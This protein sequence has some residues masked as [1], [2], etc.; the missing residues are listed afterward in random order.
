MPPGSRRRG[1]QP[2]RSGRR[3]PRPSVADRASPS[4]ARFSREWNGE[5]P[6]RP[7]WAARTPWWSPATSTSTRPS[8][9][10]RS[11]R[12]PT[13]ASSASRSSAST[14]T[15]R[16]PTTFTER[17]GARAAALTLGADQAYGPE[18][19][20]LASQDQLDKVHAHV[21]DAV[22][23]G[24]RLVAGGKHRPDIGPL[25]Y[26]PTVLADVTPDMDLY[27]DETFGPLCRRL[28]GRLRRRGRRPGQRHRVRPQRQR[29]LR[30]HRPRDGPS[31]NASWPARST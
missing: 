21:A 14:S 1:R 22:A 3:A 13:R 7:S 6:C 23:K 2:K 17:F 11:P 8:R 30:R 19:G 20:A 31:Q 26:E 4:S 15:D 10:R 27:R 16:W 24:A 5:A 29:V 18:V 12:S 28:P 9:A 25:F